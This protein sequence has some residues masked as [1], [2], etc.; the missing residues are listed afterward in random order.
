MPAGTPD[1][2]DVDWLRAA[3]RPGS[4]SMPNGTPPTAAGTAA[5]ASGVGAISPMDLYAKS[6]RKAAA[7]ISGAW[8]QANLRA[9][10]LK[11]KP[12]GSADYMADMLRWQQQV[13][14]VSVNV[15]MCSKVAGKTAYAIDTL[16]RA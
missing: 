8:Q 13:T 10:E 1:L 7:A 11:K 2:S 3:M 5:D 4:A 9:D 6:V 14:D 16:A 15:D 12:V